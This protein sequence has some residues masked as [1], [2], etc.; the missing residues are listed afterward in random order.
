VIT[1]EDPTYVD[2]SW[3][4]LAGQRPV[5][6]GPRY[7]ERGHQLGHTLY[8]LCKNLLAQLGARWRWGWWVSVWGSLCGHVAEDMA[9]TGSPS[10]WH[11]R[12]ILELILDWPRHPWPRSRCGDLRLLAE[13]AHESAANNGAV[14]TTHPRKKRGTTLGTVG[15]S[16]LCGLLATVTFLDL[17]IQS[18]S[19]VTMV[20]HLI[21]LAAVAV[22]H[23]AA[24]HV[25]AG[26]HALGVAAAP[27]VH[28]AAGALAPHVHTAVTAV[29][30]H[31]HAAVEALAP[32]VQTAVA[33][34]A[35][36]ASVAKGIAA[37]AAKAGVVVPHIIPVHHAVTAIPVH[38]AV[39]AAGVGAAATGVAVGGVAT[40]GGVVAGSTGTGHVAGTAA[41]AT[42]GHDKSWIRHAAKAA[43]RRVA[44]RVYGPTVK[45]LAT[46]GQ[47]RGKLAKQ[48]KSEG[49]GATAVGMLRR[50]RGDGLGT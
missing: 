18:T 20:V 22:A 46:S 32:H 6:H 13:R 14:P 17:Y 5:D 31:V 38:H 49:A 37:A 42:A 12:L 11:L 4:C 35:S 10:P 30:P 7:P 23:A 15:I 47:A 39:T 9:A 44:K 27:H 8:R 33:R 16:P 19:E 2:R 21:P 43:E 40:A 34:A 29:A 45:E 26:A 41:G 25:V 1:C 50:M 48:L 28:A 36:H 24:P 3:N